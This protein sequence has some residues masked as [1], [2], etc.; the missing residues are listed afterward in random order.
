M[1]SPTTIAL[2]APCMGSGKTTVATH[3]RN[4]YGYQITPFAKP[5][6]MMMTALLESFNVPA[7]EIQWLLSHGKNTPILE[8]PGQ[9]TAR[10]LMQLLGTEWG[11]QQVH[12]RIWVESWLALAARYSHVV[13]D[14]CRFLNE[15][16]TV[17]QIPGAQVWR[18]TCQSAVITSAHASE[19]ALNAVAV[20]AEIANNG[21]VAEL[22][23][24]VD[25]LMGAR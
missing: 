12:E 16:N 25:V 11:R 17:R 8:I 9:P 6:R 14:D 4:Q 7:D 22:L 21:T 23:A 15:Y 19:G 5:L 13:T 20:D 18:I 10:R 1:T 24:K 2:I 3:L